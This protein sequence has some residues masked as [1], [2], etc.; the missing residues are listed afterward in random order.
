MNQIGNFGS[1]LVHNYPNLFLR[2]CYKNFFQTLQQYRGQQCDNNYFGEI[3][4]TFFGPIGQYWSNFGPKIWK[5][6][7]KDP[8]NGFLKF[9][10]HDKGQSVNENHLG[11]FMY[12][13]S[14][15]GQFRHDCGTKICKLISQD[16]L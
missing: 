6:I 4:K 1:I 7:S 12:K 15:N 2:I 9:F 8:L 13:T 10:H 11:E 16:L 3:F 5:L 14:I